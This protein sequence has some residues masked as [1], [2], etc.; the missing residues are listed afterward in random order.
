VGT[1]ALFGRAQAIQALAGLLSRPEVRLVTLTGPG[2][3]AKT[4]LALAAAQRVGGHLAAGSGFVPLAAVTQPEQV[5]AAIARAVGADLGGAA[6]PLAALVEQLGDDRWLLVLDNLEQVLEVAGDLGE[7]LARGPGVAVLA[8]S[9]TALGLGA[10]HEY[11]VVPLL[12]S[13]DFGLSVERA[14]TLHPL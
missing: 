4:R 9:R 10:E 13:G 5:V 6:A 2:G 1:T 14:A 8:T 12:S 3:V 7:L 11:P